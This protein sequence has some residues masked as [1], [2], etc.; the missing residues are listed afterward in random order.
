MKATRLLREDHKHILRAV[1][2]LERMTARTQSGESVDEKDLRDIVAF[3][4]SFA[5]RHHQGKEEAVL[6]PALLRD[7]HQ[8]N[9]G[10]LCHVIFEHN[11][12]RSLAEGLEDAILA[13][14]TKDFLFCACQLIEK[15]RIHID[16]EDNILFEMV[17]K[18]LTPADDERIAAELST[19]ERAWQEHVRPKLLHRLDEME[20][21][22]VGIPAHT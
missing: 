7:R 22:Y 20:A 18:L 4:H 2:V 9:Y 15:L 8:K 16:K 12:E 19:F 6:F 1:D 11:Q 17:D 21:T 14:K 3:L 13:R 5:D 10:Q